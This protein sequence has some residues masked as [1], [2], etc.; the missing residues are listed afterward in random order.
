MYQNKKR[1]MENECE[2]RKKM[3]EE[4]WT[5]DNCTIAAGICENV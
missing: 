3:V 1:V 2:E 5:L 4:D